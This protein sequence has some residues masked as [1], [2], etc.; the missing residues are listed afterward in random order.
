MLQE[1]P[2]D[3][4]GVLGLDIV[5]SDA[6]P[7]PQNVMEPVLR[8]DERAI[9]ASIN[10]LKGAI[11]DLHPALVMTGS[12]PGMAPNETVELLGP[13]GQQL[14]A[15]FFENLQSLRIEVDGEGAG[16]NVGPNTRISRAMIVNR[17]TAFLVTPNITLD[18]AGVAA[19]SGAGATALWTL[20][21][22]HAAGP[23]RIAVT[24]ATGAGN[25][26]QVNVRAEVNLG[27]SASFP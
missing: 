15:A 17:G 6:V 2:A 16:I 5:P 9:A 24:F 23:E 3:G 21:I 20:T 27:P 4:N 8:K 10:S 14:T 22:A 7:D 11:Q 18:S 12:T 25:T 1:Q 13:N 26:H 19:G